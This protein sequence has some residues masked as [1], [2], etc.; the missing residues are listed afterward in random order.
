[1]RESQQLADRL[2]EVILDGTWIANTNFK[3]QL[4]ALDIDIANSRFQ[5]FN[6]ISL[7]AQHVHYYVNG[8]NNV[9]ENGK[10]EIRDQFSFDFGLIKTQEEWSLFL[11]NFW[12]DTERLALNIEQM[13]EQQLKEEFTDSKYGNFQ[14]NI[15]GLI[16]HSYYHLGQV[17]LL[18]KLL[19]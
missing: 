6:T 9:F 8:I 11:Q 17:V 1:M 3:D 16:E 10:L 18:K 5:S 15:N 4:N 13:D 12:K 7:L 19:T 2:R 14:R